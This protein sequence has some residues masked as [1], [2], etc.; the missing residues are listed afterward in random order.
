M[1][2]NT[3]K[4]LNGVRYFFFRAF[5]GFGVKLGTE[6]EALVPTEFTERNLTCE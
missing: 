4:I 3:C 2:S 5:Y 6:V 1:G